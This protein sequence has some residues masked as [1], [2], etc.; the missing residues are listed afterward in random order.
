MNRGD[1]FLTD[2]VGPNG[3]CAAY[4]DGTTLSQRPEIAGVSREEGDLAA[5]SQT[6]TGQCTAVGS[7]PKYRDTLERLVLERRHRLCRRK[8]A[9]DLLN[10]S[11][12]HEGKIP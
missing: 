10:F 4:S 8:R 9:D 5:G 11:G 12:A 3:T 1:I 7:S 6:Q 2:L